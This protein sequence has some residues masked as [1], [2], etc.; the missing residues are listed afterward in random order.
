MSMQM[1]IGPTPP[2]TGVIFPAISFAFSKSTSP[3]RIAFPV[4]S[5][6]PTRLTPTSVTVEPG[7]IHSGFTRPGTPA[8]TT[9]DF[10]EVDPVRSIPWKE[11]D[12]TPATDLRAL[13]YNYQ[14]AVDFI[15]SSADQGFYVGVVLDND[16]DPL[17]TNLLVNDLL[18]NPKN[19]GLRTAGLIVL[20]SLAALALRVVIGLALPLLA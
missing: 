8:A 17:N 19:R 7:L 3:L 6:L 5:F 20:I 9:D 1:V 11:E 10:K 13:P 14:N 18:Y 15:A 12:G 16:A 4:F 2:G